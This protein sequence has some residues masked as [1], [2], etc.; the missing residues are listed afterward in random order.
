MKY[1]TTFLFFS[2]V[3]VAFSQTDEANLA[4]YWKFRNNFRKNFI[5]IGGQDGESVPLN[6][7]RP[8]YACADHDGMGN[9]F[10]SGSLKWGDAPSRIG[11][12][13]M[14][15]STEYRLLK[16]QGKDVT[17]VL[18]EIYYAMETFNRLDRTDEPKIEICKLKTFY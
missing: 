4:K 11:F 12:Y 3:A 2:F 5:K 14:M 9:F 1:I 13:L 7:Y 10:Q 15:L 6:A 16:D 17:S 18:N 8:S